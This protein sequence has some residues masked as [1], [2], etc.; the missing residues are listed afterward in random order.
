MPLPNNPI[1]L[2][3]PPISVSPFFQDY[4]TGSPTPPP[5]T[6]KFIISEITGEYLLTEVTSNRIVAEN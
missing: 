6:G 1:D 2:T 3:K 4:R 5:P